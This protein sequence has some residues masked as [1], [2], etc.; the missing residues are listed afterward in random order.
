MGFPN[1]SP[2]TFCR[3]VDTLISTASLSPVNKTKSLETIRFAEDC[4][5]AS[6]SPHILGEAELDFELVLSTNKSAPNGLRLGSKRTLLRKQFRRL[7]KV[8]NRILAWNEVINFL[9]FISVNFCSWRSPDRKARGWSILICQYSFNSSGRGTLRYLTT[10]HVIPTALMICAFVSHI[11]SNRFQF[12]AP[13][14]LLGCTCTSWSP[15]HRKMS[16]RNAYSLSEPYVWLRKVGSY[17]SYQLQ[18]TGSPH[19]ACYLT[20]K[21]RQN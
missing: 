10:G 4:C 12:L 6:D 1:L 20:K 19:D 3:E 17:L 9:I 13:L 2:G 7:K 18:W 15:F 21:L 11:P 8:V 14:Y 16:T 5:E